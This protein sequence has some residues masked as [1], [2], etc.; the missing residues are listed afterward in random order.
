MVLCGQVFETDDRIQS[1]RKLP[2]ETNRRL[3]RL[4]LDQHTQ[5]TDIDVHL[6]RENGSPQQEGTADTPLEQRSLVEAKPCGFVFEPV[7][8]GDRRRFFTYVVRKSS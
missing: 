4:I 8:I 3:P 2:D 1:R 7:G 6:L 5:Q